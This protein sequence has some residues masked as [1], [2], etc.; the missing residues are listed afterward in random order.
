MEDLLREAAEKVNE[1]F[2]VGLSGKC[3]LG[4]Q[5]ITS[6]EKCQQAADILSLSFRVKRDNTSAI[7]GCIATSNSVSG[8][9]G[10]TTIGNPICQSVSST[11]GG[12]TEAT[13]LYTGVQLKRTKRQVYTTRTFECTDWVQ[14]RAYWV[15]EHEVPSTCESE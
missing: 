13:N 3:E 5:E 14:N 7:T 8:G 1:K 15:W 6:L 9:R 10:N 4:W 11:I 12:T 2:S